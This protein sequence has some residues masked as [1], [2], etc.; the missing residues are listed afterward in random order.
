MRSFHHCGLNQNVSESHQKW[1]PESRRSWHGRF[2]DR[3]VSQPF[4]WPLKIQMGTMGTTEP[5]G[6][7]VLQGNLGLFW[8]HTS[9][10]RDHGCVTRIT[11]LRRCMAISVGI[12]TMK[13]RKSQHFRK[14]NMDFSAFFFFKD[15]LLLFNISQVPSQKTKFSSNEFQHRCAEL[16][17][18][19]ALKAR[20]G[21]TSP[22]VI[23]VVNSYD[24]IYIYCISY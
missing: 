17:E 4:F 5:W 12:I 14:K 1:R 22:G 3:G 9:P 6:P 21:S 24:N 18:A 16:L 8:M 2:T 13:L 23:Y 7:V 20:S 15:F 10:H 19:S 11:H